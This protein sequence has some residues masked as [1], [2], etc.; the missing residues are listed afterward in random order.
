M[1]SS[2]GDWTS[3]HRMLTLNSITEVLVNIAHK[4]CLAQSAGAVEYT[5][6][7]SALT[8]YYVSLSYTM[9]NTE[10]NNDCIRNTVLIHSK[11]QY[12]TQ[13]SVWMIYIFI[14]PH[15]VT[16]RSTIHFNGRICCQEIRVPVG[17]CCCNCSSCCC[18]CSS[19]IWAIIDFSLSI[20]PCTPLNISIITCRVHIFPL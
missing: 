8:L 16:P 12:Y 15:H 13:T 10:L 2:T 14:V 6:Y 1:I 7:T 18:F 4:W 9:P 17:L 20:F 3:N 19:N 11:I 5:D